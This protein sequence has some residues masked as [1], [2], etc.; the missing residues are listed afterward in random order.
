[1]NAIKEKKSPRATPGIE[2]EKDWEHWEWFLFIG[3]PVLLVILLE[4]SFAFPGNEAYRIR[5]FFLLHWRV[6]DCK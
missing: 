3:I 5:M 2:N 1:M 6:K 4:R